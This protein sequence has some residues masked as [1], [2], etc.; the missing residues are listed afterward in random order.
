MIMRF[1]KASLVTLLLALA[2]FNVVAQEGVSVSGF[3]D[4]SCGAWSRS[5]SNEFA[6]A[7]YLIWFRG[8]ISGYNYGRPT[9]QVMPDQLP[10]ND[11]IE[12]YVDKYCRDNPLSGFPGAA[13]RLVEELR[14]ER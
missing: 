12:L 1:S 9:G 14:D 5:S 8:F 10:S 3:S 11:T 6:R 13:F 2:P 7:Q 4:M